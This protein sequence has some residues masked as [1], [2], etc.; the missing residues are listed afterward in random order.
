MHHQEQRLRYILTD[1]ERDLQLIMKQK[2]RR[3]QYIW[4]EAIFLKKKLHIYICEKM[5]GYT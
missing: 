3:K 2:K 1:K 4:Y 5:G